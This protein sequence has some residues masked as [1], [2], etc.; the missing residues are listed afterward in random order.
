MQNDI[1]RRKNNL[2]INTQQL[3]ETRHDY[4]QKRFL[5]YC[6]QTV[7]LSAA[8]SPRKVSEGIR[9]RTEEKQETFCCNAH[10]SCCSTSK[11]GEIQMVQRGMTTGE[12]V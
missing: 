5:D 4:L 9:N 8:R 10:N 1:F 7:Q 12:Y 3:I 2:A 11:K 6:K